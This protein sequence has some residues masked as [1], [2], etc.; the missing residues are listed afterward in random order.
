LPPRDPSLAVLQSGAL[1]QR[2][3]RVERCLRV[4]GMGAVYE[5]LDERTDARRALK[6]MLPSVVE[7]P[8]MRARF[9]QEARI[10]GGVLSEHIVRTTDAGVDE[11]TGVPFLVMELL[12][13]EDVGSLLARRGALPGR[14]VVLYLFQVALALDRTHAAGIVH[15]DLKPENLFHTRR[16]DGSVC[17][18]VLD[19]GIAKVM[20]QGGRTT[21]SMGTPLYMPPEQA[22]GKG[23][24]GP[25]AD[26]YALGHLAFT[27]LAGEPYWEQEWRA[28]EAPLAFL[29]EVAR[30]VREPAGARAAR[31]GVDLPA[32]FDGWFFKATAVHP[33]E[34]FDGAGAAVE[35]LAV[36]LGIPLPVTMGESAT[37]PGGA[38]QPSPGSGRTSAALSGEPGSPR[39]RR[40]APAIVAGT[41]AGLIAVAVVA[42][43][44]DGGAG[45]A[46]HGG[47]PSAPVRGGASGTPSPEA[48]APDRPPAAPASSSAAP[49]PAPPRPSPARKPS[50]LPAPPSARA[51]ASPPVSA[52]QPPHESFY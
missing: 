47:E 14:E 51:P 4:G 10:T 36:A 48:S 30:G 24:L 35:A 6:I 37:Q 49:A 25:P 15:R 18:K 23:A 28:S 39:P 26:V 22:T 50:A 16:D 11:E 46:G 17:I 1:F 7:D 3:Y 29:A 5:V 27:L 33:E 52:T 43:S 21:K 41:L 40:L 9:A 19:F 2:R 34:R 42:R 45:R 13:G 8:G 31:H 38:T 20:A 32:R 44:W 12:R